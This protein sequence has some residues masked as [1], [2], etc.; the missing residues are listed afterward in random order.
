MG[1]PTILKSALVVLPSFNESENIV[2]LTQAI[3]DLT[4]GARVCVV[5]DSSPDGTA[6][7]VQAAINDRPGWR[8]RVELLV[9]SG[10]DGRGSAVRAG[11]DASQSSGRNYDAYVE[12]DCDFSHEP[13]AIA[14]GLEL[15]AQG[16]DVVIG[17][18]YPDG[19]I[20]N[21]PLGRRVFSFA[22]NLLARAL[23]DWSVPDYTNGFRFYSPAA[24]HV[25]L[26]HRQTQK[27]YIYL[28]ESLSHLLRER[29]RV[30]VFPITFRNRVRGQSNTTL[31]EI[32]AALRGLLSVTWNHRFGRE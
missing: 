4:P 13:R 28:S 27:G 18:R 1:E 9:R 26:A 2:E 29:L 8:D 3:L 31:R 30:A 19:V 25:L 6:G 16:H 5:D 11:F 32:S 10:K 14:R 22:A 24:M 12:M 23:I 7:I 15:L 20:I 21:W 17:A